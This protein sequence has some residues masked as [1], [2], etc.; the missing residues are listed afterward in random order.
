MAIYNGQ[1]G[2]SRSGL[3]TAAVVSKTQPRT[4]V[5]ETIDELNSLVGSAYPSS[6]DDVDGC[7]R[8]IQ[9][10]LRV[11][12]TNVMN[13]EQSLD[14]REITQKHIA[15]LEG[16]VRSYGADCVV[17]AREWCPRGFRNGTTLYQARAVCQRAERE[18]VRLADRTDI[19]DLIVTYLNRL[20]DVLFMF[21]RVVSIRAGEADTYVE[22]P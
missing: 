17:S 8:T 21:A 1:D 4:E 15:K 18:A 13:P 22:L 7:L 14:E 9:T 10:H 19:S 3:R 11:L 16:W 2:E 6:H 5:G 12:T 20:S